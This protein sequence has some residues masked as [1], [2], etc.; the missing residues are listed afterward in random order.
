MVRLYHTHIIR[1]TKKSHNGSGEVIECLTTDML[2]N[3]D[4]VGGREKS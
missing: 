4:A 3:S 1:A 2:G